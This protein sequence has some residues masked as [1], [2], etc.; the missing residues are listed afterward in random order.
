MTELETELKAKL[1]HLELDLHKAENVR[2]ITF[3]ENIALK[4]A[5]ETLEKMNEAQHRRIVELETAR[6]S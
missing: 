3:H 2:D 5:V 1:A 6:K 4:V